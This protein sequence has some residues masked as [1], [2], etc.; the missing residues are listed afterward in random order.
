VAA[1]ARAGQPSSFLEEKGKKDIPEDDS[2]R[3][4]K[5]FMAKM[6]AQKQEYDEERKQAEA[7]TTKARAEIASAQKRAFASLP[8]SLAQTKSFPEIERSAGLRFQMP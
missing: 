1:R 5:Q 2:D 7:E 6:T 3:M 8:S 4:L